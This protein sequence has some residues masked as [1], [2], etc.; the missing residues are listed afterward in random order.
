MRT[1]QERTRQ[2]RKNVLAYLGIEKRPRTCTEVDQ[3]SQGNLTHS[4]VS[5]LCSI[6]DELCFS[7][8]LSWLS[9]FILGTQAEKTATFQSFRM[10]N[11][12]KV[13][14][15]VSFQHCGVA[16]NICLY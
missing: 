14:H 11:L 7:S 1:C 9:S 2:V 8:F 12:F 16:Q 15:P 5:H 6:V 3:V 4:P 10:L 13:N